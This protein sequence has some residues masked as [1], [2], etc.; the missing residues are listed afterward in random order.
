M[1]YILKV[2]L[3]FPFIFWNCATNVPISTSLNDFAMMGINSSE[4]PISFIVNNNL[5][6]QPNVE[7]GVIKPYD[8]DKKSI[9]TDMFGYKLAPQNVFKTMFSEF[10]SNKYTNITSTNPQQNITV[11]LKDFWIEYYTE[12]G[13]GAQFAVAMVGGEVNYTIKAKANVQLLV[14]TNGKSFEKNI[15]SSAEEIFVYGVGTGTNTSNIYK[16]ENS[17]EA[18]VGKATNSV[19]NKVIMIANKFLDN[20][21]GKN[22]ENKNSNNLDDLKKLKSL[23]DDGILT[24][25][26]Y[27]A[28]KKQ[29]LGL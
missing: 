22:D 13:A 3:I 11:N 5:K 20:P 23:Y 21:S 6:P 26:E 27:D 9:R 25:E 4:I 10:I 12:E 28:K 18:K 19:F 15:I 24:K 1:R 16:G 7:A 14:E 8:K 29:I 2:F 17:A